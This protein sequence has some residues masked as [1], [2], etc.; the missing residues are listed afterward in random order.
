[1]AT[2]LTSL[3][4]TFGAV[5]LSALVRQQHVVAKPLLFPGI[6]INGQSLMAALAFQLAGQGEGSKLSQCIDNLLTV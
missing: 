2:R 3:V 5:G 6:S 1:M 4:L